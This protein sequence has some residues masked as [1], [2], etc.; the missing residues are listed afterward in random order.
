M[1]SKRLGNSF[2]LVGHID[3]V[4]KGAERGE[5]WD[6]QTPIR[7]SETPSQVKMAHKTL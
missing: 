5:L 1:K 2:L 7:E 4:E 6:E 3:Q